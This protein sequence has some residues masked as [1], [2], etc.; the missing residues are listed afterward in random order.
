[1]AFLI[2]HAEEGRLQANVGIS[3]FNSFFVFEVW[4]PFG[5]DVNT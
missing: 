2:Y 3:P 4:M 1:M 5:F